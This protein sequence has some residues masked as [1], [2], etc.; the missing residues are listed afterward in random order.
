[1]PLLKGKILGLPTYVWVAAIGGGIIVG[2][3]LRRRAANA[4]SAGG[5]TDATDGTLQD[6]T[7]SDMSG[8]ASGDTGLPSDF[9]GVGGAAPTGDS[10]GF[11]YAPGPTRPPASDRIDPALLAEIRK[12]EREQAEDNAEDRKRKR[13]GT[14]HKTQPPGTRPGTPPHTLNPPRTVT[15]HFVPYG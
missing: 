8:T 1:M 11:S 4:V 14:P 12:L 10:G 7:G 5:T 6:A 2:I 9:G 15:T 3:Y 13:S